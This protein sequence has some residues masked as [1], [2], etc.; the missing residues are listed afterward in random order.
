MNYEIA[1]AGGIPSPQLVFY[2]DAIDGNIEQAL[3]DAGGPSRLWPHVKTH[4]TR[5]ITKKL[6]DRGVASFKCATFSECEMVALCGAK[7][8]LLAYPLVG[9]NLARFCK[10]LSAYPDVKWYALFDNLEQLESMSGEASKSGIGKV[11][12]FVDV[13]VGLN[14]TGVETGDVPGF[15]EK[16]MNLPHIMVEGLHCYDGQNGISDRSER[17]KRILSL[18]RIEEKLKAECERLVGHELM[19]IAGGT[20]EFPCYKEESGFFCSPGTLFLQDHGYQTLFPDLKYTPAA[21]V[22]TRVISNPCRGYFT[23]DCGYKAIAADPAGP[24]G[25][26]VGF[27]DKADI[28]FQNEEHWVFKMKPGLESQC[29]KVGT[30]FYVIPTHICPTSALYPYALVIKDSHVSG[31]WEIF[32]RNRIIN[33]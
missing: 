31:K 21:A 13:N 8:V 30:V 7:R 11:G 26:I 12:I 32:A 28:L 23:L 2:E 10:L 22:L 6:I 15:I 19:L 14:R 17:E 27:E 29:P 25:V 24:R 9:P 5:E 20:P 33:I 4:K 1:D 3:K 18:V 16:A